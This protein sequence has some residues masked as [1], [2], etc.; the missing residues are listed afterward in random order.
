MDVLKH[1]TMPATIIQ[2]S[3]TYNSFMYLS[4]PM[5]CVK[6]PSKTS[7]Q[8]CLDAFVKEE[9][10]S[11]TEAWY[12]VALFYGIVLM[13]F[14]RHCPHCKTLRN[15]T[16]QLSLSRLPPILL[17]HL[18]RFSHKGVFTDKIETVVDFPL[19]GL[20]LTNYMP[21]AL[22]PGMHNGSA[23]GIGGDD[24]RVQTPPYKY[25]LYGVTNHFG[26]L[27]NGHCEL[28]RCCYVTFCQHFRV[29]RYRFYRF[30]WRM[31]IL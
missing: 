8:S 5:P 20:D 25:D 19:K 24:P 2:T 21:P 18:K 11:G 29:S 1:L 10:L 16:K 4:L 6:G 14:T 12:G 13:S 7:L 22:P 30:S 15:A 17:I 3:T 23:N 28:Y 27:S 26:N 31:G 9:V